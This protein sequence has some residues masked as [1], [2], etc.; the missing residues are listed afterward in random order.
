MRG[1]RWP[2]VVTTPAG[3]TVCKIIKIENLQ[4]GQQ[5]IPPWFV[6]ISPSVWQ[7]GGS[8]Q[9]CCQNESKTSHCLETWKVHHH[10]QEKVTDLE[11]LSET[12]VTVD[13]CLL[14]TDDS[15]P[16]SAWR[17]WTRWGGGSG[18]CSPTSSPCPGEMTGAAPPPPPTASATPGGTGAAV[19]TKEMLE[20]LVR[21]E[22]HLVSSPD[23]SWLNFIDLFQTLPDGWE[24]RSKTGGERNCRGGLR[25]PGWNC[26]M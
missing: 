5:L 15:L 25:R 14:F 1:H 22:D 21:T 13:C 17:V 8:C 10:S 9:S 3:C 12:V 6:S 2:L 18:S 19:H 7:C 23:L 4:L 24:T 16:S 11:E 26:R 20:L